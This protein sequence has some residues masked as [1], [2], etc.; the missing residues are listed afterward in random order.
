M[1][2]V[3]KALQDIRVH[4]FIPNAN[5]SNKILSG[6]KPE[7]NFCHVESYLSATAAWR[8][9]WNSRTAG[10][11]MT[12]FLERGMLYDAE[13]VFEESLRRRILPETTQ[14]ESLALLYA[15]EANFEGCLR[16]LRNAVAVGGVINSSVR[17]QLMDCIQR[18]NQNMDNE[19]GALEY[20]HSCRTTISSTSKRFKDK[21]SQPP[22]RG[23]S[24]N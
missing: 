23:T 10:V 11:L 19:Q 18:T 13:L 17:A 12:L 9:D 6:V 14:L 5:L 1:P 8:I 16:V 3:I 15:R 20:K 4:G 2:N 22:G 7:T 24:H 21:Y